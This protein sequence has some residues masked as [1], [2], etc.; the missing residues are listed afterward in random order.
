MISEPLRELYSDFALRYSEKISTKFSCF[1]CQCFDICHIL[2]TMIHT[3][4]QILQFAPHSVMMV[5]SRIHGHRE[6]R[7]VNVR[8]GENGSRVHIL[9][10]A[11]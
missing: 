9:W 3:R 6:P 2:A 4:A 1:T 10:H 7:K 11:S 5:I 8:S